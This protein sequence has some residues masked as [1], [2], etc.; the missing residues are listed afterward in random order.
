M[1]QFLKFIYLGITLYM[2]WTVF[3]SIMRSSR[4]Y[5]QQQVYVKEILQ[6]LF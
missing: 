6:Y 2:F 3:P 4:L 1:H 5:I